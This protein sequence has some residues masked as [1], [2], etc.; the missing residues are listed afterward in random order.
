M[1]VATCCLVGAVAVWSGQG[2]KEQ[3]GKDVTANRIHLRC[4]EDGSVVT[5]AAAPSGG[6]KV[7]LGEP[8]VMGGVFEIRGEGGLYS[9]ELSSG[10]GKVWAE[11]EDGGARFGISSGGDRPEMVMSVSGNLGM[12]S[13]ESGDEGGPPSAM[14]TCEFGFLGPSSFLRLGRRV[15]SVIPGPD[16]QPTEVWE[17]FVDLSGADSIGPWAD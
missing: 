6:L 12:L 15:P 10:G 2:A 7:S 8:G 9:L 17:R 1:K 14:T 13:M 11:A 16:G 3:A 5:L 4:E